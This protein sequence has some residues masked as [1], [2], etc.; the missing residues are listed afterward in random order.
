MPR[1]RYWYTWLFGVGLIATVVFVATKASEGREFVKLARDVAPGWL[2]LGVLFQLGTYVADARSW[3]RV[4]HRA[5]EARPLGGFVSLG[6]SKLF[7]D[8]AVPSGGVS[9]T[10]VV[11]RGLERRGV[12]RPLCVAAVVVDLYA[13]YAAYVAAL[14]AAF[15]VLESRGRVNAGLL[16]TA[17]AS[18]C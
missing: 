18:A 17:G 5:G 9:G 13:Y 16:V 11:V 4:L 10:L 2:I 12:R 3:Q 7:L 6:L 15:A 1:A 8:Q 14:V